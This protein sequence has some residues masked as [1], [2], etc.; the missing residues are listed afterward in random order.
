MPFITRHINNLIKT[1]IPESELKAILWESYNDIDE[2]RKEMDIAL[3]L[4]TTA[5][6]KK[7]NE[8]VMQ[9]PRF[10]AIADLL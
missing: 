9:L 5:T 2:L 3:E 4:K 7:V 10:K 8:A 6:D 1:E